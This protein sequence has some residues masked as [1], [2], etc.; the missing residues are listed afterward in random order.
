[1][2][3]RRVLILLIKRNNDPFKD[4]F[5]LP[6]GFVNKGEKVEDAVIR[7]TEEELSIKV[8]P[9]DILGVYSDPNRDPR[10]HITTIAFICKIINGEPKV[11]D[12]AADLQW[13]EIENLK[14]INLAGD[15]SKILSDYRKWLKNGGTY[16]SSK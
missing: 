4:Y 14:N 2:D 5:A 3:S 15:H 12:D 9:I 8:E 1:M 11:A 13:V 7:E 6:G 16:W 10:G